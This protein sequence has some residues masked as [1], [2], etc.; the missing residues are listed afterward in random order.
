MQNEN[1]KSS[2]KELIQS[3]K[4]ILD[5]KDD[6]DNEGSEG[7]SVETWERAIELLWRMSDLLEEESFRN[8][9]PMPKINPANKGSIDL[10]WELNDCTLLINI[11]HKTEELATYYGEH[12][13]KE[14]ISGKFAT[15]YG[16][17][18][19]NISRWLS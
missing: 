19:E 13:K 11:P 6:W 16:V 15:V 1:T 3:S 10:F 14:T 5:L 8:P 9:I 4:W 18:V 2:V 7:Y 17:I 12:K